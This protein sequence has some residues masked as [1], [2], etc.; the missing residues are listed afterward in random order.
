METVSQRISILMD[1]FS[2]TMEMHSLAPISKHLYID[3]ISNF[4]TFSLE[5]KK[6]H[7]LVCS[8]MYTYI[9]RHTIN[10]SI[11]SDNIFSVFSPFLSTF[12]SSSRTVIGCK[13]H[14][15]LAGIVWS[16][17][18]LVR[19][20]CTK[21]WLGAL[22]QI[23]DQTTARKGGDKL[24]HNGFV[25]IFSPCVFIMAE[26]SW[27]NWD[28]VVHV[29]DDLLLLLLFLILFKSTHVAVY[30]SLEMDIAT[31]NLGNTT[32][33]PTE[34]ACWTEPLLWQ[35]GGGRGW[36]GGLQLGFG[37]CFGLFEHKMAHLHFLD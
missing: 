4:H 14:L 24:E 22:G 3:G 31:Q 18:C 19:I 33:D 9:I 10:H 20:L 35:N 36:R 27:F 2:V 15:I 11:Q 5:E 25:Q 26:A 23:E 13:H 7:K 16:L 21:S 17:L 12:E 29:D 6:S 37:W 34:M 8:Y 1:P 28:G 32:E 30:P